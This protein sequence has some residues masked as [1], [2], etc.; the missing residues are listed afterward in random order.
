M[1][2]LLLLYLTMILI[3]FYYTFD[4]SLWVMMPGLFRS[5]QFGIFTSLA[6]GNPQNVSYHVSLK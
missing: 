4:P 3:R 2:S 6:L 1:N 5:E